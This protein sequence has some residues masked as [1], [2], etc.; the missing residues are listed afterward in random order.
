M[1]QTKT[2]VRRVVIVGGVAGGASCAA[3]LRRMDEAVEIV[4]VERGPFVSFANCG[5]PYRVGEVIPSDDRLLLA[6]PELFRERFR[7]DVLVRTEATVIDRARR[8]VCLAGSD[9]TVTEVSYDALVLAPGALPVRPPLPGI[10]LPGIFTVRSIPDVQAIRTHLA[11]R[12]ARRAVVIGGGFI[13]L[14]MAENLTHLGLET[15]IVEM[16]D[17]IMPP[18]DP[19]V[20]RPLEDHLREKGIRLA[21]GD[22]VSGFRP[23]AGGGLEVQTAAGAVHPADVVILAIGVKPDTRLAREAGLAL[24]ERGGIVVDEQMRTADPAIYAVGDA[25]EVRSVLDGR[26]TLLA[27]A[28]PANRQ[29]RVA[30]DAICGQATTFRGVQGT[31]VV[32]LFEMAAGATGWTEKALRRAGRTDFDIHWLHAGH[33][34]GYY[35]G[36]EMLHIKMISEQRTGRLLGAQVVGRKDVAR[37]ID[38]FA[39]FLQMGATVFDLEEAELAYSPQFG[40]AKDAVNVLGMMGAN[41]LRGDYRSVPPGTALDPEAVLVDVRSPEEFAG[42]H[43]AGARN[44]PLESL[45]DHLP[46]LPTDRP[47]YVYCQAGKRGYDAHRLLGQSGVPAVNLSGGWLSWRPQKNP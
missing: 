15:T 31:S 28:G 11:G 5:L 13:G 41:T 23:A 37:K 42:G 39:A 27:L 17:Q 7:I 4:V 14:E 10:D 36:A 2:P 29:G 32:G 47:V 35:P 34:A 12:P 44:L 19:E 30:A 45:R 6:T 24:G 25:V 26:P 43:L 21:L 20:V 16:L 9:G 18:L 3:R 46:E 40:S 1:N 22:G 8:I 33:H 38:V